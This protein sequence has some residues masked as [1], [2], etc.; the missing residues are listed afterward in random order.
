MS[1]QTEE[2]RVA[3][4]SAS[5][6]PLRSKSSGISAEDAASF[7]F[8]RYAS[9]KMNL[10]P[11]EQAELELDAVRVATE[12][13]NKSGIL[14][15][16]VLNARI[17]TEAA[18]SDLKGSSVVLGSFN[19]QL[20]N[21]SDLMQ[22]ATVMTG[23]QGTTKV[24]WIGSGVDFKVLVETVSTPT[25]S[26]DIGVDEVELAPSRIFAF[27]PVSNQL[28]VAGEPSTE[29]MIRRNLAQ[30][31]AQRLESWVWQGRSAANEIAG[32]FDLAGTTVTHPNPNSGG[33]DPMEWPL[34]SRMVAALVDGNAMNANVRWG[35][36]SSLAV[37]MMGTPRAANS[38]DMI[39]DNDRRV[40][41]LPCIISPAF[42]NRFVKTDTRLAG[43]VAGDF[44]RLIIGTFDQPRILVNPW[45]YMDEGYTT[46]GLEA[47]ASFG[48]ADP[49]S[50]VRVPNL[51]HAY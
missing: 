20:Y 30:Q 19:D 11:K 26:F 49:K 21:T 6:L 2:A 25:G 7:S 40:F 12:Q 1:G 9:A 17:L 31:F 16:E 33:G 8:L 51:V 32:L 50:I 35:M 15:D 34:I 41:N 46:I 10:I 23:L 44:S 29:A 42:V 14:P 3:R 27:V 4:P 18:I 39:M 47:Y 36:S 24:P 28:L 22:H 38:S 43:L 48:L 45:K 37:R 13:G 5:K